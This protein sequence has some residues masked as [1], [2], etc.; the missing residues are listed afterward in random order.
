MA[1]RLLI[2]IE[3]AFLSFG[4]KPLFEGI[5]LYINEGD[6]IC[7]V[8]KN[9]VGKT[10]LMR[11]I[12]G[13]LEL[14]AGKRFVYPGTSFAYLAQTFEFNK[15]HTVK[16]FVLTGLKKGDDLHEKEHLADIIIAPLELDPDAKMGQLSGGQLRRAG[17]AR[18]LITEPD[19][20]LLDEPTNHMDLSA[21]EWLEQ[22]LAAYKGALICISHDRAFLRAISRKVFWIDRGIIRVCPKG[23]DGFDDWAEMVL[24]QEARELQN[25]QK[26]LDAEI[27][28]TQGGVTGR[29]KR[30]IRRLN[31]L[32]RLREK[33]RA[34][35]AAY[36]KATA[37]IE[38]DPLAVTVSSKRVVEFKNVN[39]SFQRDGKKTTI[40]KDFT[41]TI[42]RGDRIGVLGRNG[43]G[44]STFL[45]LLVD[46]LQPDEG[47]I[48]RAKTL[49]ISYFDQNRSSLDPTDTIWKTLCPDG[50]DY[51]FLGVG[52]DRRPRHVCG[53]LKDFLFDPKAA[54]DRVG[55]LSGGQQN[56]LMLAKILSCPGN[57]LILDEPTND[58]DMDT[59]DILQELIANYPGTL[60]VVS[61]D[62]DFLDRTVTEILAFE[63]N[64]KVESFIGGYSDY[65]AMK[66]AEQAKSVPKKKVAAVAVAEKPKPKISNKVKYELEKLPAKIAVL[67][68]EVSELGALLSDPDLYS[69]DPEKFDA[70]SH[71]YAKAKEELSKAET[72]WLELEELRVAGG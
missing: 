52:A 36:N 21:I 30:N 12:T 45:K 18:T 68:D 13:D 16:E 53:Y 19:I 63:G 38:V 1:N 58:L 61:H 64:G 25:M 3:E 14:D 65:L 34:D 50:G 27:D 10:T 6:K 7:L 23:Y 69:S 37:S 42:L 60:V 55:T 62:R 51:V 17:L 28:W 24:E 4:G 43:S 66:E 8:G 32:A 47:L 20:L 72:R 39:K 57:L 31:Q 56:R 71:R 70:A 15:E 41:M 9:G 40:L 35:K 44:K 11:L 26:K 33:I 46:E 5:N 2:G 59:L 22:Y 54:K 29:R 67:E 48:R 49:D